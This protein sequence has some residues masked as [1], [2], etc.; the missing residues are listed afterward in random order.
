MLLCKNLGIK[1]YSHIT[2]FDKDQDFILMDNHEGSKN[3][4][5]GSTNNCN[6]IKGK[7][8]E[9]FK[10]STQIKLEMTIFR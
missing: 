5:F 1:T 7:E 8:E 2:S 9:V 10:P 3:G 6:G 4:L